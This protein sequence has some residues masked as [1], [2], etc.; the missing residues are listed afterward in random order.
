VLASR[1]TGDK[2]PT[3]TLDLDEASAVDRAHSNRKPKLNKI[4]L[5]EW[6]RVLAAEE[7]GHWGLVDIS[8]ASAAS[9]TAAPSPLKRKRED[10]TALPFIASYSER[11]KLTWVTVAVLERFGKEAFAYYRK[12]QEALGI[13]DSLSTT[14]ATWH[15]PKR[16]ARY[17]RR[18]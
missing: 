10:Q 11:M 14:N 9:Q 8:S 3:P 17:A 13:S 5:V 15:R 4:Y 2:L 7:A 16:N 1:P 6:S 12:Q 18:E